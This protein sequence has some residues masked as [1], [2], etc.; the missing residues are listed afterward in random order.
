MNDDDI[1]PAPLWAVAL[2]FAAC[3]GAWAL[4]LYGAYALV[5]GC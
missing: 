2:L 4:M 1:Y 3:A 5:W